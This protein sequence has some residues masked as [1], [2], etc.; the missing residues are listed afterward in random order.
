M[1]IV[2][3]PAGMEASIYTG[4]GTSLSPMPNPL[5]DFARKEGI[6]VLG[7]QLPFRG[8]RRKEEHPRSIQMAAKMALDAMRPLVRC[9]GTSLYNVYLEKRI[10]CNI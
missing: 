6:G 10:I 1:R 2:Q 3:T 8:A 9:I 7:V 4:T 5:C